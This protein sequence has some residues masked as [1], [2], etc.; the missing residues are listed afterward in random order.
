MIELLQ[1]LVDDPS[2][3]TIRSGAATAIATFPGSPTLA[4]PRRPGIV[5]WGDDEDDAYE[6]FYDDEE[7][8][9]AHV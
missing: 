5:A 3:P 1:D 9:R 4:D 7:I 6:G 2:T 8:G